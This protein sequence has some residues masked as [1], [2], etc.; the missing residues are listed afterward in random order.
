MTRTISKASILASTALMPVLAQAA[1]YAINEQSASGMGTAYAGMAAVADDA[2]VV[3]YN[4]AAMTQITQPTLTTGI[5][6]LT[7]DVDYSGQATNA[8]GQPVQGSQ[9]DD[10]LPDAQIPFLYYVHPVD[11]DVV[12]GLGL[13]VPFGVKGD[14]ADDSIAGAFADETELQMITLQPSIAWTLNEQW[15]LGL[16]L[17]VVHAQGKLSKQLELNPLTPGYENH[18]E[19]AGDDWGYGWNAGVYFELS[20]QT[21]LGLAY[22]S[23]VKLTLQGDSEFEQKSGVTAYTD[24]NGTVPA[25]VYPI[26]GVAGNVPDQRSEIP[27]TTP[28]SLTLSI[29]HQLTDSLRLQAGSTWTGWSVFEYLDILSTEQNTGIM[30][31]GLGDKHI[32]HIVEKWSDTY[33]YSVGATYQVSPQW[34]LRGGVAFDESPIAKEHRTARVPSTDRRW[35]TLGAQ[36]NVSQATSVDLAAGYLFMDKVK[37]KEQEH[38]LNDQVSSLA[39]YQAE[40]DTSALGIT[41]Q[42]TQRF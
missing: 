21:S 8:A 28:A 1:G 24:F 40:Y 6:Y 35:V 9:G 10:F 37:V 14:Y 22:R 4:P 42:L 17:D 20:E 3:F 15:S 31:A 19:V 27:L 36:Y 41:L 5:T 34:V 26:D 29:A 23:E 39:L 18:Y 33:S 2:S 25:G 13:F 7:I 30:D 38:D 16:G 12:L 32:G 11:K